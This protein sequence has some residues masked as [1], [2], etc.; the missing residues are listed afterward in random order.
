MRQDAAP[1]TL[2]DIDQVCDELRRCHFRIAA[3][4]FAVSGFV[5]RDVDSDAVEGKFDLMSDDSYR[6]HRSLRPS[7]QARLSSGGMTA[8]E[9][10][11]TRSIIAGRA[12]GTLPARNR[13]SRLG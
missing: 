7:D 1:I 11:V 2:A 4:A 10:R 8:L 3:L 6:L 12:L 9:A 13:R 5:G